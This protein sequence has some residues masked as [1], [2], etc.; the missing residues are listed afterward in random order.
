M[1]AVDKTPFYAESGGQVGDRG[2]ILGDGLR[3]EVSDTTKTDGD[4]YLHSGLIK[5]GELK[6]GDSLDL[7]VDDELRL[8]TARNHTVTHMLHK[9]L[10]RVLGSHVAQ[11]GS[12]V[13]ED[14]LRFDFTHFGAMTTDEKDRV[15]AMVN[16]I[17]LS[18][19]DVSTEIMPLEEA[20][21]KA[22]AALFDE[23]YGDLVRVVSVG[24]YSHELCG[25]TH[26]DN[27]SV[28]GRFRITSESAIASG[29]RRIEGVT[30]QKALELDK[31]NNDLLRSTAQMLK[32]NP[33]DLPERVGAMSERIRTLEKKIDE[34]M[35]ENALGA[36]D[37]LLKDAGEYKGVKYVFRQV[38]SENQ[39]NLRGIAD[40]LKDKFSGVILLASVHGDKLSFVCMAAKEAVEAGV[41]AG[42][43]V[44]AAASAAGGGGGG[45]PD[46]AQ[47]GGRDVSALDKALETAEDTFKQM[48]DK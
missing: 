23:K 36:V 6:T 17:I 41:H 19:S 1:L 30:G 20:K 28:A 18:N 25:G 42:N 4:I 15:E 35:R 3:I 47:A 40:M 10:R 7:Q 11:A 22:V 8:S 27:S 21:A 39:N 29:V 5:E 26:L 12:E 34:L 14:K 33:A 45:R 9:A 2:L 13:S 16:E 48:L 44:R 31:E 24:D 43:I 38:E 37:D 46:M 32:I